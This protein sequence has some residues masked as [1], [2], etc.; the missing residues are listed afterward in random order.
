[1]GKPKAS[2]FRSNKLNQEN[3]IVVLRLPIIWYDDFI[4]LLNWFKYTFVDI[5]IMEYVIGN[6]ISKNSDSILSY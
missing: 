5:C 1:M 3:I 2:M 6:N 4:R